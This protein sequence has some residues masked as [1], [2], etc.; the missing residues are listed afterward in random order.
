MRENKKG[1]VSVLILVAPPLENSSRNALDLFI[2][3]SGS[4]VGFSW[5]GL[6]CLLILSRPWFALHFTA[7]GI[8]ETREGSGSFQS[9]LLE[10]RNYN[11][12]C[13]IQMKWNYKFLFTNM[14][15]R[16]GHKIPL[17]KTYKEFTGNVKMRDNKEEKVSLSIVLAPTFENSSK[18]AFELN[19]V[20]SGSW[21][22]LSWEGLLC[23][24]ILSGPWFVLHFTAQRE[25]RDGGGSVKSVLLELRNKKKERNL[26]EMKW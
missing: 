4:W 22:G 10:L 17:I 9:V 15:Y 25:T 14:L 3:V 1:K 18:N 6:L 8:K 23:L 26:N 11:E 13:W 24:L 5:E 2:V 20:V 21:V 12:F 19:S 16:A 7:Q